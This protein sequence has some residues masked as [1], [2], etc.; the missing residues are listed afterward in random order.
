MVRAFENLLEAETILKR[1][2]DS[3]GKTL[4]QLEKNME[5][6]KN[7]STAS[8]KRS[9]S[10]SRSTVSTSKRSRYN[11]TPSEERLPKR[12]HSSSP[13][14]ELGKPWTESRKKKWNN[15]RLSETTSENIPRGLLLNSQKSQSSQ[16]SNNRKSR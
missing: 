16:R 11:N 9:F 12:N 10:R 14:S 7:Q 8:S 15:R 3:I 13:S 2:H 5:S 6:L 1:L 4:K